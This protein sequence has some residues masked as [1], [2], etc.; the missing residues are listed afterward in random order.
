MAPCPRV[1]RLGHRRQVHHGDVARAVHLRRKHPLPGSH[2][3]PRGEAS[4]EEAFRGPQGTA[5]GLPWARQR[6]E[7]PWG[8]DRPGWTSTGARSRGWEAYQRRRGPV[9]SLLV[10]AVRTRMGRLG[11]QPTTAPGGGERPEKATI[12]AGGVGR[13]LSFEAGHSLKRHR[14]PPMLRPRSEVRRSSLGPWRHPAG[15]WFTEVKMN[16]SL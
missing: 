14:R 4:P 5:A 10:R 2:S 3:R 6:P 13:L 8:S 15:T 7:P 12:P 1:D 9:I 16:L 11:S